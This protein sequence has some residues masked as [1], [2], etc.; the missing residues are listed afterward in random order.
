MP[1]SIHPSALADFKKEIR[2][3][4]RTPD[5][6]ELST[7]DLVMTSPYIQSTQGTITVKSVKN[8]MERIYK[9]QTWLP[10]FIHDKDIGVF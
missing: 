3:L 2:R 10:D 4:N 9:Y 5:E 1:N 6:F 8:G 7:Q